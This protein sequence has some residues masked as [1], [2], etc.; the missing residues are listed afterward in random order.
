MSRQIEEQFP[1]DEL[2]ER[3]RV[4]AD[5]TRV[6]VGADREEEVLKWLS[7]EARAIARKVQEGLLAEA[8]LKRIHEETE[9]LERS[10]RRGL[11]NLRDALG[12]RGGVF[13]KVQG[14]VRTLIKQYQA[15]PGLNEDDLKFVRTANERVD[16]LEDDYRAR[17]ALGQ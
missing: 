6:K 5:E 3:R 17:Q 14:E 2:A 13:E 16:R 4:G 9:A 8:E 7:P 1:P 15:R 11:S 10:V 12:A